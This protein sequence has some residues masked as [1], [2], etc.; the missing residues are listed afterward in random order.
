MKGVYCHIRHASLMCIL[1]FSGV[2]S[3]AVSVVAGISPVL[4][5]N[6]VP[7]HDKAEALRIVVHAVTTNLE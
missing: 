4:H 3:F 6:F 1:S 5:A 2:V 7:S